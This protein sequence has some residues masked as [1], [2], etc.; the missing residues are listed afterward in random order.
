VLLFQVPDSVTSIES[1]DLY[2][3]ISE[4]NYQITLSLIQTRILLRLRD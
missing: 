1:L 2:V 4:T 3:N